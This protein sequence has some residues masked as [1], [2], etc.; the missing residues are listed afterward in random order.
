[1]AESPK[2]GVDY[3][4]VAVVFYC[5]DG[6]GRVL[7]G[8]RAATKEEPDTWE[9]G[10]GKV[11]L[12]EQ[13]EDAVRREVSEEYGADIISLEFLGARDVHRLGEAGDPLHWICFD[14]ACKLNPNLT[15]NGAPEEHSEVEWFFL[16]NLPAPLYS[17]SALVLEHYKLVP[18]AV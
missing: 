5:H 7:L 4:G 10:A 1:M 16:S 15:R 11:E 14:W 8:K 18:P 9:T 6:S 3:I 2:P 13:I 17:L 12:H